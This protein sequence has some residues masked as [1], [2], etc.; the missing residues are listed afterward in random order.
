MK[1]T[2]TLHRF[3]FLAALCFATGAVARADEGMWLFN[4]APKKQI[5]SKYGFDLTDTWLEH[6]QKSAVR[7]STGGSGSLVSSNGLV[8]TNH[9]VGSDMLEKLSTKENDFIAAGFYAQS[10]DQE[11]KCPDIEMHVLWTIE[12]VTDKVL[13]GVKPGMSSADANG[14]KRQARSQLEE[15]AKAKTGLHCETVELYQG[16]RYHLYSY[17]RYTDVRLVMAPEKGIAFFG[18]DPDNFEFP[19]FDL[20]MCF[21]RIYD[22]GK[23]L[24]PEHYLKWS[25]N[26]TTENDLVF[27]AGHPGR[28]ERL[29]TTEHLEYLRD[30]SYP[31]SMRSIWRREVQLATFMGRS[32]ENRRIAEGDYFGI[33]N[34]RK[35]RTGIYAG[36]MDP[37]IMGAKL[38]AE[39]KLR[40]AV[41]ANPE[42]KKQWGDGW[43]MV[44]QAKK[45][46]KEFAV[47]FAALGGSSMALGGQL[48]GKAVTLARLADEKEKP[49]GERLREFRS[50]NMESLELQLFSPA[51]IYPDLEVENLTA[52]LQNL[53]E[54]LGG[55]DATV[56]QILDGKSP[57]AR[58]EEL[59]HGTK[60]L[61]VA[62]RKSV[63]AGG[64]KAI[65]ES[66][67]PMIRLAS[68]LDAESRKL[69][70][71][72]EDE[73]DGPEKLGYAKIAAANFAVNGEDQ[74]PD[75][76]FTLRLSYGTVKSYEE[77]GKKVA[78]Y[79]NFAGL[80]ERAD[81]RD[82]KYPFELPPRWAKSKDVINLNTPYNFVS[83]CD[84][85]GG[86]SGSPVVDKSGEVVGLIFDGNIQSL[87][88]DIAYDDKQARAVS[89]D[90]RAIIESLRKVYGCGALADEIVG[91]PGR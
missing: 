36:L 69:R 22:G 75:A 6:V 70:K 32:E 20:D 30:F 49:N 18:G 39:K 50:S 47:R 45:T 86:N 16:G 34:T 21:F 17:K 10:A 23:P 82:N 64:K 29:F 55:N 84:I 42:W 44:A 73:V 71:R 63:A 38:E 66:K 27:V 4:R 77:N 61:D 80:Y 81:E 65:Q 2:S 90:S 48:F 9:H 68:A 46:Q 62:E 15:E 74:Y 24:R 37:A 51:P 72:F 14:A 33:Q 54:L 89:V 52:G 11:I 28:T 79:T 19:R 83:T 76:T 43:D 88:L 56:V 7:I 91:A 25:R 8:M 60:L 13:A 5:Q 1:R 87:V 31:L 12:D 67:D 3:A 57:R 40:A 41:D 58:A 59:V 78:P 85:I 35:A 53:V 26:G